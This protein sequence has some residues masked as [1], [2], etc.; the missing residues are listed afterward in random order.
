MS[1]SVESDS[2]TGDCPSRRRL[3]QRIRMKGRGA[4]CKSDTSWM[5]DDVMRQRRR[6]PIVAGLA[7]AATVAGILATLAF[8]KE[9]KAPS[10]AR[11]V[12]PIL[13]DRCTGCHQVGGIAPFSLES[14]RSAS[15]HAAAIA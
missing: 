8:A 9:S 5:D 13:A 2:K 11:E 1:V 15:A 4:R 6:I 14:S 7:T 3:R 12:A 10:F